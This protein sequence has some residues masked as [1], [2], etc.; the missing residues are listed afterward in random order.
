MGKAYV[1]KIN[2]NYDGIPSNKDKSSICF[3]YFC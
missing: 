3:I 1:C 2:I